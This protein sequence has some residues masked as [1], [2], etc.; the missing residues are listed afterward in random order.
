M[1]EFCTV[2]DLEAFLKL[3]IADDDAS[4][5]R[6][7]R[8]A[9]AAIQD[10][11]H[12]LLEAVAGDVVEIDGL[13]AVQL[14][15][16]EAPV[17]AISSV[18]EDGVLVAATYYKWKPSGVLYRVGRAWTAGFANVE[19]TYSHGYAELPQ[20]IVDVCTR[21]AARSYQ[22]ALRAA[23]LQGMTGVTAE[24]FPDYQVQFSSERGTTNEWMLGASG[25][26]ILLLSEQRA[27]DKYRRRRQA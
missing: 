8:E 13:G 4:A 11:T 2:D 27:L 14:V 18:K 24:Q 21:V 5:L 15:L 1:A 9:S 7:I 20:K 23:E 19:V 16:P 22:A 25:A 17:T 10:Y 12:Q 26:P 6:A 3:T